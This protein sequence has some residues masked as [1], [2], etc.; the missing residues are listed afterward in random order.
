MQ[1]LVVFKEIEYELS[2]FSLQIPLSLY[3]SA[4]TPISNTI[5]KY[6]NPF[7]LSHLTPQ[8]RKKDKKIINKTILFVHYNVF[9]E[10]CVKFSRIY[11]LH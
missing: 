1:S 9:S 7:H 4:Y 5:F 3:N 10:Y 2:F 11:I 8:N 6:C